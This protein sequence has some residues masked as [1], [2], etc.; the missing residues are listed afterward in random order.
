MATGFKPRM[1]VA[2][3][4]C[5]KPG[6]Q[7]PQPGPPIVSSELFWGYWSNGFT[8][9]DNQPT[10]SMTL[11]NSLGGA[12]PPPFTPTPFSC[13]WGYTVNLA[14]GTQIF[15][16]KLIQ[17][18]VSFPGIQCTTPGSW[19]KSIDDSGS[20]C[21][22]GTV[23]RAVAYSEDIDN[24][25]EYTTAAGI[26]GATRT[27]GTNYEYNTASSAVAGDAFMY[28]GDLDV[29]IAD[30]TSQCQA[31]LN[32]AGWA[33]GNTMQFMLEENGSDFNGSAPPTVYRTYMQFLPFIPGTP[34]IELEIRLPV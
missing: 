31:V 3:C 5:P 2:R 12:S 30:V 33:S 10:V 9:I 32:R 15:D 1:S 24:A 17:R 21:T 20:Q 13:Y 22:F 4:C 16:A 29:E 26:D 27:A 18:F 6:T 8:F 23:L 28:D 14:Q 7:P 34:S 11:G 25:V 19:P